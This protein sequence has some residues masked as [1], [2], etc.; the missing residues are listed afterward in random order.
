MIHMRAAVLV[1]VFLSLSIINGPA[2]L[3]AHQDPEQAGYIAVEGGKIWY[4][5]NGMEH[6]GKK[7]ALIV[8]HGGPGG[9]H[10][11]NMPLVELA[12][13][14]PVILYDQ[15]DTGNSL[16][17]NNPKNWTVSRFLSEID[18]IRAALNV[19]EVIVLGHS[20]GGTLAAEYAIK[21]PEGLK[22]VILSSPL[23]DTRRWI[24][25]ADI[26][27]SQLP[28]KVEERL[29]HHEAEGTTNSAEYRAAEQVFLSRHMCRKN[30]CPGEGFRADG[31]DWNP[32][33]YE[34][35][36]GPTEFHATGTLRN[37]N[38]SGKLPLITVPSLVI[39]GEYDEAAPRS[40]NYFGSLMQNSQTF[41][42]PNAGHATMAENKDLYLQT[43]RDFIQKSGL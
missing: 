9:T 41:I 8:L 4:R 31:P 10:R 16:R 22:A 27:R 2:A 18:S 6:L 24:N 30:P 3:H 43:V 36:W 20:W 34:Y 37:Y 11:S 7:A 42:V 1:L 17:T 40:C 21:R 13:E 26:W 35:M 32:K 25:D 14:R 38:I 29:R 12:D 39:C 5:M 33:L 15:L 19:K 28:P 23:I